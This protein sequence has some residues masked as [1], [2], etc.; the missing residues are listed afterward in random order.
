[1]DSIVLDRR[2]AELSAHAV[3][4]FVEKYYWNK[5]NSADTYWMPEY[6]L[7][8]I[9]ADGLCNQYRCALEIRFNSVLE[10]CGHTS[11]DDWTNNRITLDLLLLERNED[12]AIAA[13][14]VKGRSS[15]WSA[16][17]PDCR[18]LERLVKMVPKLIDRAYLIYVSCP[19]LPDN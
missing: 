16:F 3:N 1:M 13:I 9:I 12:K 10:L 19:M 2:L 15:N 4:N 17:A 6:L 11:N 14:E 7:K 18:R 8:T 5:D